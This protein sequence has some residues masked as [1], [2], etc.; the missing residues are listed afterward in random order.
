[1]AFVYVSHTYTVICVAEVTQSQYRRLVEQD[2]I[3]ASEELEPL[4]VNVTSV[5]VNTQMNNSIGPLTAWA[6]DPSI[7][8]IIVSNTRLYVILQDLAPLFPTK[9]FVLSR[10][11]T[12]LNVRYPNNTIFLAYHE[13][14]VWFLKGVLAGKV[15]TS[16]EFIIHLPRIEGLFIVPTNFYYAGLLYANPN[17]VLYAF[18]TN[19]FGENAAKILNVSRNL[20][21]SA[22]VFADYASWTYFAGNASSFNFLEIGN[23]ISVNQPQTDVNIMLTDNTLAISVLNVVPLWSKVILDAK[24]G[25][26]MTRRFHILSELNGDQLM[27]ISRISPIVSNAIEKEIK[28]LTKKYLYHAN[29]LHPQLHC[30]E[31]ITNVIYDIYHIPNGCIDAT[32][33]IEEILLHPDIFFQDITPLLV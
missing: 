23:Q 29:D 21:P 28:K 15:S 33:S 31:F 16:N 27:D 24:A 26:P 13:H 32:Q 19:N 22:Q 20:V 12:R 4:G 6:S 1:L 18:L 10:I 30:E 25:L 2:C 7:D 8:M 11:P 17:A 5:V 3:K 14:I 9:L